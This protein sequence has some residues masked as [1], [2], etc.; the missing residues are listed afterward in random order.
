MR[1]VGAVLLKRQN[2]PPS[3]CLLLPGP[4]LTVA[5]R[6]DEAGATLLAVIALSGYMPRL[7]GGLCQLW[8][9]WSLAEPVVGQ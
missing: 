4:S 5:S 1:A 8:Q 9:C 6:G 2:S 7:V 3:P